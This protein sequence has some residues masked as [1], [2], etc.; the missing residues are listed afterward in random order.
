MLEGKRKQ[1]PGSQQGQKPTHKPKVS[2]PEAPK[3]EDGTK[4]GGMPDQGP[5]SWPSKKSQPAENY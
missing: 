4:G 2:R 5:D 3:P 1:K